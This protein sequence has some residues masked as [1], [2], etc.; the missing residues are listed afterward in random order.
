MMRFL[1]K[2]LNKENE[3]LNDILPIKITTQ[4]ILRT[5]GRGKHRETA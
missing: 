3:I 4:D 2:K 5:V 1:Y